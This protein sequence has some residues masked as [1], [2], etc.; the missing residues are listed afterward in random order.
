MNWIRLRHTSEG[1]IMTRE[2]E[3]HALMELKEL[4]EKK[5]L[6]LQA[7]Y[8]SNM[9]MANNVAKRLEALETPT[10][11]FQVEQQEKTS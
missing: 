11:L 2:Q 7:E 4:Y 8:R 1:R 9:A 3:I 5:A 10:D 6:W